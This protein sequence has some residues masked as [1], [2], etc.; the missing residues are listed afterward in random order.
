MTSRAASSP[1]VLHL[2]SADI[3]LALLLGPQLRAFQDAGWRVIGASAPGPY[4]AEL[5]SWG[6]EHVALRHATRAWNPPEDMRAVVELMALFRRLRP[7]VVHTHNPKPGLYGRLAGRLTGMGAVV[8]TVHGLYASDDDRPSKRLAVYTAERLAA[9]C[10]D[11]ELVQNPEDVDTL[12]R[13]GVPAAKLQLIGNGIDLSRFD[14]ARVAGAAVDQ[15]RS[16]MG[17][18]GQHVVVGVVG[19]LV[20]EKGYRDVFE[21]ARLLRQCS[22]N[23]KFVVAGP[24]DPA[25]ADAVDAR[26]M[27][28]ARRHGVQFLGMR[29]D[30]ERLYSAFD[31]FVLASYREG[32][33]RSAMEAA[34]M[35]LPIVATDI[36]GCRQVVDDGVTGL[37]VPMRQPREL[38]AAVHRLAADSGMR[39]TMGTAGR[40]KALKEF[41]QSRVIAATLATYDRLVGR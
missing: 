36:R 27:A 37:L 25:K 18:D 19:R 6:I 10:S 3:S 38:A 31:V 21:A 5:R 34:A 16:E 14:P 2:T 4:V 35:G 41:D 29:H 17:A 40:E 22:P 8:N 20:W 12:R 11:A 30:V 26:S 39:R 33:P 13:I 23:I 15:A 28:E 32:F 24:E 1:S 7:D 9:T